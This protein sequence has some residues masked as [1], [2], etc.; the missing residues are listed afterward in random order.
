MDVEDLNSP[1]NQLGL[2]DIMKLY[3]K[4][5]QK[6]ILSPNAHGIFT[7]ITT[8]LHINKLKEFKII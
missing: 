1:I 8:F 5:Q 4:Q 3:M 2:N 7:K 6:Y